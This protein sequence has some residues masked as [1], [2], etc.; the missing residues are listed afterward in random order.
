MAF[1]TEIVSRKKSSIHHPDYIIENK[2][3]VKT[4]NALSIGT[5]AN[6]PFII[7]AIP[8]YNEEVAIGSVVLRSLKY[9]NKVIVINDGSRD[10]TAEIAKLAGAEVIEH[11]TNCGKGV[12]IKNAFD[13]AKKA[14]ADIL[15]LIDGDGQHNPD[16]ILSLLAPILNGE[17]EIVNGSRFIND[18]KNNVPRYRRLGQ[19]VL[20]KA[21]NTGTKLNI[22][23]TQNGFRAFSRKTFNCFTFH[24]NGMAIES[25]MLMDA[26]RAHFRIKEVPINVRYDVQGSTY[27]P[28]THG[29]GVLGKVISIVSQRRP[30]LFFGVPGFLLLIIGSAFFLMVFTTF[31]TTRNIDVGSTLITVLCIMVGVLGIFTGFILNA[32]ESIKVRYILET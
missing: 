10:R 25:E 8:A 9:T 31:D 29:F 14:E 15:V 5:H 27:N 28:L 2:S 32:V 4:S 16:E 13:Y 21:T 3:G 23:D 6:K 18:K 26:A 22:T 1:E 7:V 20:T 11:E 19:E 24:E 30:L 12:A 17:A